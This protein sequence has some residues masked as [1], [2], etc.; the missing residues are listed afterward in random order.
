MVRNFA[1]HI[2]GKTPGRTWTQRFVKRHQATL[3]CRYLKNIDIQRR[4]AD[5]AESYRLFYDLLQQKLQQYRISP[6]NQYNMDEKGF[7]VGV[8]TKQRRI[9]NKEAYNKGTVLGAVQDGNRE[10]ISILAT[11]CADGTFLPPAILYESQSGDLQPSWVDAA[12][13]IGSQAYVAPS[14]SGWTSETIALHWLEEVF[15]RHTKQKAAN[16]LKYR[17]LFVDGHG[18]HLNMNFIQWCDKHRILLAVYPP[19]STHRLQPLDVSLFSPL[20]TFYTQELTDF[21]FKSQGLLKIT[22]KDFITLFWPAFLKAFSPSN[23]KSGFK[24]TGLYPLDSEPVLSVLRSHVPAT[25]ESEYSEPPRPTSQKSSI[26]ALSSSE[27]RQ[28]RALFNE[29]AGEKEALQD[30]K[31]AKMNNTILSLT[32][33]CALLKI[34]NTGLKATVNNVKKKNKRKK[35]LFEELRAQD[36]QGGLFLSPN[37]VQQ[38]LQLQTQ[39]EQD[40]AQDE[41]NKA[42]AK[43]EKTQ[44]KKDQVEQRLAN[45]Q[46]RQEQ[47]S[48]KKASEAIKQAQKERAKQAQ[49]SEQQLNNE[50]QASTKKPKP[51]KQQQQQPISQPVLHNIHH[52][53]RPRNPASQRPSRERRPP[54]HLIGFQIEL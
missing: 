38:A 5:S 21:I 51:Q 47:L 42:I 31:I 10:W 46:L 37:K 27:W 8:N 34:E 39:R 52:N 4:K 9:F 48:S 12:S 45:T 44:K 41:A 35:G 28:I 18:S 3:T 33:Q 43:Q 26:S 1:G 22:K 54:Q 50:L 36:S 49:K 40:K 53:V 14:E 32:T 30:Q 29:I 7:M 16:G 15:E 13:Y 6:E 24:K 19:H 25:Q 17:L 23:I 11:I 2:A 20:A